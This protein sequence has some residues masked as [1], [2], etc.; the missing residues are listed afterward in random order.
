[1]CVYTHTHTHTGLVSKVTTRG[2]DDRSSISGSYRDFFL[3]HCCG[4]LNLVSCRYRRF[5]GENLL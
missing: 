1:V 2:V 3:G 5:F 4:P